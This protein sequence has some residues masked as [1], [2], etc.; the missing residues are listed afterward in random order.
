MNHCHHLI[1]ENTIKR[2][3]Y[4]KRNSKRLNKKR[5][6]Q[7][8]THLTMHNFVV[9]ARAVTLVISDTLTV[10]VT[11]LLTYSRLTWLQGPRKQFDCDRLTVNTSNSERNGR[12]GSLIN[13]NVFRVMTLTS[14]LTSGG[15]GHALTGYKRRVVRCVVDGDGE[16]VSGAVEQRRTGD[17]ARSSTTLK[18]DVSPV[19]VDHISL[20]FVDVEVP[21][22]APVSARVQLLCQQHTLLEY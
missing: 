11:Y 1:T 21:C 9:P 3:I 18:H 20:T 6:G 2:D 15:E 7:D 14:C 4:S 17:D 19:D 12:S 10:H 22:D 13:I 16:V 5:T 8:L